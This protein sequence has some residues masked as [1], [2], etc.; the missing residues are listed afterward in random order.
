MVSPLGYTGYIT[1]L[2]FWAT[3]RLERMHAVPDKETEEQKYL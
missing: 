3:G 1:N 2:P